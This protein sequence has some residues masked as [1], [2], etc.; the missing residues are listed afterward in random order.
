MVPMPMLWRHIREAG[1][2]TAGE[3]PTLC[4]A[5]LPLGKEPTVRKSGW[6]PKLL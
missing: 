2:L 1:L 3:R 6:V 4:P 5:A